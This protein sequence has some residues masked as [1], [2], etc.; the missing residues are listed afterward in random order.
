MSE[1]EIALLLVKIYE[2]Q[3]YGLKDIGIEA[4]VTI[5]ALKYFIEN[6]KHE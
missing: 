5:K 3:R 4:R 2:K 1:T 6:Y